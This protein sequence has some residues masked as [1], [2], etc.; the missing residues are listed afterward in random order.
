MAY[1]LHDF[2]SSRDWNSK[3]FWNIL[4]EY[5]F[6]TFLCA[7]IF[8]LL[9]CLALHFLGISPHPPITFLMVRP[10]CGAAVWC[11]FRCL[12]DVVCSPELR[13]TMPSTVLRCFLWCY[14][15]VHLDGFAWRAALCCFA[16]RCFLLSCTM[17]CVCVFR[18]V[19]V[20]ACVRACV[21]AC[22]CVCVLCCRKLGSA[23]LSWVARLA[24]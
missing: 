2:F 12:L 10:L 19:C 15:V 14:A 16:L 8:F 3:H 22:V 21:R 23:A 6:F 7:R 4:Y 5:F 9:F 17:L 24:A 11:H 20:G 1:P 13:C 18:A